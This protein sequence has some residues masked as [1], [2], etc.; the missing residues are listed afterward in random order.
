MSDMHKKN[1]SK[2]HSLNI[3]SKETTLNSVSV[4]NLL[5]KSK[6]NQTQNKLILCQYPTI[7]KEE[8]SRNNT[9]GNGAFYFQPKHT[10]LIIIQN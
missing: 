2:N 7:F 9:R 5:K 6:K 3:S 1:I 8:F 10:E 4:S